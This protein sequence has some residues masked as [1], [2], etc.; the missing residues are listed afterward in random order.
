MRRRG[1]I[2]LI[3]SRALL[4]LVVRAQKSAMPVIGFLSSRTPAQAGYIIAAFRKGLEEAGY[5]EGRNV[6]IEFRFADEVIA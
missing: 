6:T 4:P 1:F 2:T 3:G 5:V